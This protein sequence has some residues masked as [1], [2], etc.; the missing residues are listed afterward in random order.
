[1]TNQDLTVVINTF[2]SDEKIFSCID[3]ISSN[4][5]IIIIENS[6]NID[7]KN[8]LETKYSNVKCELTGINLGYANGNNLGLSKVKTKYSLIL[9]PDTTI[10]KNSIDNF[11]ATAN[12]LPNF[13]IVSPAIQE[14]KDKNIKKNNNNVIEVENVK[15]FA[16]FFNMKQFKD[17]GFFDKNFFI[18]F[19]EID[20]CRRLKIAKKKIYLDP[21]IKI[22]HIGGSSHNKS[23]NYEMELSRNWHWMW[24]TFYY[25]KKYNGF[26]FAF[27]KVIK[28]LISSLFKIVFYSIIFE[29]NKKKI[30]YQRASG[31]INSI[32]GNKSWYRPNVF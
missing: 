14:E 11:F 15:G 31:L 4:I 28:K 32:V 3:S 20:L 13:A 30:Y 24:S 26:F 9:N 25:H 16:M 7:F 10:E 23:I 12:S 6:D 22:N 19:E 17:I 8:I 21:N 1:M 29:K 5:S 27:I 18:Y 2:N